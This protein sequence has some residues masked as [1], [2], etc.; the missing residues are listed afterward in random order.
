VD[1]GHTFSGKRAD[2][3]DI[4]K[5]PKFPTRNIKT[6]IVLVY[7]G[8]DSLVDIDVML[9]ELPH[10]T[11]AKEVPHY[12]HLDFLWGQEVESLVF[13]H[14]FEALTAYSG[15]DHTN[16]IEFRN[17]IFRNGRLAVTETSEDE[18]S[19]PMSDISPEN[20]R[21][22]ARS[23]TATT[24]TSGNRTSP[25][26]PRNRRYMSPPSSSSTDQASTVMDG[27]G[28]A[29]TASRAKQP[30]SMLGKGLQHA[31]NRS[32]STSS[33]RSFDSTHMFGERGISLGAAKAVTGSSNP[34][35]P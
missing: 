9:K 21:I 34:S 4:Q 5:V 16:I 27:A 11:I 29:R 15:R 28:D 10:H 18:L 35:K 31:R 13:P 24:K 12:E 1:R 17:R 25:S 30:S 26:M 2:F 14:V 22:L 8:S 23:G 19:S 3:G 20:N 6:P 33:N 7:G 32:G